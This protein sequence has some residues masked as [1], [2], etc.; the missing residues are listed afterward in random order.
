MTNE[1]RVRNLYPDAVLQG[2]TNWW[3]VIVPRYDSVEYPVEIRIDKVLAK[4]CHS[5]RGAWSQALRNA[6]EEK[7]CAQDA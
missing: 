4:E 2:Y 7:K 5:K 6:M 1:E 3:F